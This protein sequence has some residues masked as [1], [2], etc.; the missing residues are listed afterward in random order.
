MSRGVGEWQWWSKEAPQGSTTYTWSLACP[1]YICTY[2]TPWTKCILYAYYTHNGHA[3]WLTLWL[4]T[5]IMSYLVPHEICALPL[6]IK[7]WPWLSGKTWKV[8]EESNMR[9]VWT[10]WE[11]APLIP[12][13]MLGVHWTLR[14]EQMLFSFHIQI[15]TMDS[16]VVW[17]QFP[18][19]IIKSLNLH[20]VT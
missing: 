17:A 4:I 6:C 3:Q 15:F 2:S 12:L 20:N 19:N 8:S 10:W 5:C 9:A 18:L 13:S 11:D 7:C 14:E 16:L 1:P